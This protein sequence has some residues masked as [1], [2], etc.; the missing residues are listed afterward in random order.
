M[1]LTIFF[2]YKFKWNIY[3]FIYFLIAFEF[4]KYFLLVTRICVHGV[5]EFM[6]KP[7]RG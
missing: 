3:M 6:I 5:S 4:P 2:D 7:K 1:K